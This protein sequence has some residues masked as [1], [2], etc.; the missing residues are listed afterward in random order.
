M[1]IEWLDDQAVEWIG[2][3][4]VLSM[5]VAGRDVVETTN[6]DADVKFWWYDNPKTGAVGHAASQPLEKRAFSRRCKLGHK[7]TSQCSK[8]PEH[9]PMTEVKKRAC[10]KV[11]GLKLT[12]SG[13]LSKSGEFSSLHQCQTCFSEFASKPQRKRKRSSKA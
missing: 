9:G 12:S 13:Q 5:Q 11:T 8:L 1:A 2:V 4:E 3:A 10:V 6:A 7:Y